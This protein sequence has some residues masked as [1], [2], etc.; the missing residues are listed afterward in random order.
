[1]P[2]H[3]PDELDVGADAADDVVVVERHERP[4]TAARGIGVPVEIAVGGTEHVAEE[5]DAVAEN[6]V[7]LA[8]G[9]GDVARH[10]LAA[11]PRA[12]G[13]LGGG[14]EP[15]RVRTVEQV[16]RGRRERRGE[17][18][19]LV[20]C[21]GLVATPAG[22]VFRRYLGD[23]VHDLA[24]MH[25]REAADQ[26]QAPLHG[27]APVPRNVG[28]V[29]RSAVDPALIRSRGGRHRGNSC[30]YPG[31]HLIDE[32]RPQQPETLLVSCTP[33]FRCSHV[34]LV[35]A[36]VMNQR[37]RSLPRRHRNVPGARATSHGACHAGS[38]G[39]A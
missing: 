23:P 11:E 27:H 22:G 9:A 17:R 32:F 19:V 21:L 2:I 20:G 12:L 1:M 6:G 25:L 10:E 16:G 28:D 13:P 39:G 5:R 18:A 36:R 7:R 34:V 33:L 38:S 30:C 26:T 31:G 14:E 37:V 8:H 35:G 29:G 3:L 4:E 24:R 15:E